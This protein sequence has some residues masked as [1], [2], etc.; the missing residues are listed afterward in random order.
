MHHKV[1]LAPNKSGHSETY[2]TKYFNKPVPKYELPEEEMPAD[3]AY[4][5]IHDELNMDGNPALN[6]ASFC[7]T[8]M[9][10][11]ADK[12][13]AESNNKNFIDHDEY[14]QT[15]VIHKRCVNILAR[16]FNNPEECE[17][18]GTATIGSSE[19]IMLGLLA[20]KWTWINK[21][22]AQNKPYDKPN[23]IYGADVHVCWDKFARYFDVEPRIIPMK[24]DRFVISV[25]EVEKR[26][27]ENTI[28]VGAIL[29]TTFTGQY[30]PVEKINDLLLKV[31]KE[32]GWDIPIHVDGASGGFIA[33]FLY[34][35]I[36]WD[37]R[38]KQVKSINVSGH[39]YGLVYPGVGWL[40]F[41]DQ[42]DVPK[43]IIFTVNYLGGQMPTY[44]LN[45]SRG[46]AMIL[47]QYYMF[48]RL[49]RAGFTRIMKYTTDNAKYLARELIKTGYFESLNPTQL[50]PIVAIKLKQKKNFTLYD[51][52]D[53]LRER[54][55]IIPAYSLPPNAEETVLMRIVVRQTF[56]REMV[57]ILIK[58]IIEAY[59][60]LE[61]GKEFPRKPQF[62]PSKTHYR[63][64]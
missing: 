28:C 50:L 57:D 27:D 1:K 30:D 12:L 43:D 31:K 53:K 3:A 5:L 19:A 44:T 58:D 63:I 40:V 15:E 59:R 46:S 21:R 29:G 25:E 64:C 11:E 55:W 42:E 18:V 33:P 51:L 24:P 8:W 37:F 9:E 4:Q 45:F 14:P 47:A 26:L 32:K 62:R 36:K 17:A 22:K 49:G 52:S 41:R 48:L 56:S 54:G 61:E 7:T 13:I 34:P 60:K 23:I 20:H 38:L 16:L 2:S 35:E 6:L 39:K 10:P